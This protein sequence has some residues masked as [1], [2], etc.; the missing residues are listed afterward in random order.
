MSEEH[1]QRPLWRHFNGQCEVIPEKACIWV[2][3]YDR[4]KSAHRVDELKTYIPPRNRALQ[5]TSSY[6]NYLLNRDSRPE[7]PQPLI[8]IDTVNLAAIA[9]IGGNRPLR[10]KASQLQYQSQAIVYQRL[11]SVR[12]F[13][14]V[15]HEIAAVQRHE[16]RNIDYRFI[17]ES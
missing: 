14:D 1:A 13:A 7:H 11:D 12:D 10:S 6:I 17:P 15:I 4:A 3:V 8:T 16:L 5:G 2:A 9:R